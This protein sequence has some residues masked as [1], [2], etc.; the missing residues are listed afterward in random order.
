MSKSG[1]IRNQYE[2]LTQ[3]KEVFGEY[4]LRSWRNG[5]LSKKHRYYKKKSI[6]SLTLKIPSSEHVRQDNWSSET[7]KLSVQYLKTTEFILAHIDPKTDIPDYGCSPSSCGLRVR[8][9]FFLWDFKVIE[10][11]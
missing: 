2:R 8:T 4:A 9:A 5:K 10:L 3:M 6:D 1:F 11:I 7:E